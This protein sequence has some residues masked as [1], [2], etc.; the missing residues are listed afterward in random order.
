[1]TTKTNLALLIFSASIVSLLS[2]PLHGEDWTR[3]RGAN[4]AG[5][6]KA[7]A[8]VEWS[9]DKNL[10]WKTE[11]PGAGASSPIVLGDKV[12]LTCYSGYGLDRRNPGELK[13]L[14]RHLVCVDRASGKI[15]WERSVDGIMPED[16]YTGM[17]VPEH[18]YASH[19]PVTDG[20]NIYVFFGKS[21]ALAYDLE[22]KKLW[23][24]SVG[25]ESDVRRWG[26]ASSPILH[27]NLLIVPAIAES[28]AIIALDKTT[29]KEVW[30]QEAEGLNMSWST[31][32]IVKID[33]KRSDLVIGVPSEMWGMNPE[34][35]K[36]RWLCTDI[37]GNSFF[38][39]VVAKDGIVYGS[40][41]G[42]GG[43][44]SFAVKAGGKGDV[45]E[46]NLVW[47]TN[48]RNSY[49]TPVVFDNKLIFASRGIATVLDTENGDKVSQVRMKAAESKPSSTEE[50]PTRRRGGFGGDYSSPVV[51]GDKFYYTKRSGETFVFSATAEIKQIA[52]N[53]VTNETEDFSST[54]AVTDGQIFIRSSKHLYCVETSEE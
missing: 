3:F 26:S 53:R 25:T 30:K 5:I 35:G 39:S 48:D 43:G 20:K 17:G 18:G 36:M 27:G 8:P 31:P 2:H 42:R 15:A 6:S 46:T 24:T 11:L 38:T 32:I 9:P 21:G 51:A 54:P 19:T 40:L 23:Q 22:G 16:T 1:M 28:S 10:K 47:S 44:G 41:G 34:T 4:G 45:T 52:V 14:K 7:S 50:A 29:G 49:S 12:F 37:P 13:D 33:D